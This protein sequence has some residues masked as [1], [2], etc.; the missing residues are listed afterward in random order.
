MLICACTSVDVITLTLKNTI[1]FTHV[2]DCSLSLPRRPEHSR[3]HA[4]DIAHT[5]SCTLARSHTHMISR[6]TSYHT[7][8]N[9]CWWMHALLW[10]ESIWGH[11]FW[12]VVQEGMQ[13]GSQVFCCVFRFSRLQR[14]GDACE[15]SL[16][17]RGGNAGLWRCLAPGPSPPGD[18][19]TQLWRQSTD[20]QWGLPRRTCHPGRCL[21]W[22]HHFLCAF[23]CT[24][25]A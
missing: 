7:N 11:S 16:Y 15:E 2:H 20:C 23:N 4:R 24:L 3:T 6:S 17:W 12:L 5:L 25:S 1:T 14:A 10:G 9:S 19:R 8:L 22:P 21:C 18:C 13:R